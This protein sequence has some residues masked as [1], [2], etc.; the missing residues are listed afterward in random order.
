M[1]YII[2]TGMMSAITTSSSKYRPEIGPGLSVELYKTFACWTRN[3][4]DVSM[5]ESSAIFQKLPP[6]NSTNLAL[7]WVKSGCMFAY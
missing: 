3:Y 4:T 7:R 1:N 6:L 2:T 5:T